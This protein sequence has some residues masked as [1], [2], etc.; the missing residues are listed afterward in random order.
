MSGLQA[1]AGLSPVYHP[2]TVD[3][4]VDPPDFLPAVRKLLEAV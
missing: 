3:S 2:E 1:K 4:S